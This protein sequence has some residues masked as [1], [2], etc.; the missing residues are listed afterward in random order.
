[1]FQDWDLETSRANPC[2]EYPFLQENHQRSGLC[3]EA[4]IVHKLNVWAKSTLEQPHIGFKDVIPKAMCIDNTRIED[5]QWYMTAQH[6]ATLDKDFSATKSADFFYVGGMIASSSLSIDEDST[7]VAN[8]DSSL[9]R[10]RS[11]SYCAQHWCFRHHNNW[12]FLLDSVKETHS[13]GRRA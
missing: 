3:V 2:V 1:M 6:Y 4:V 5:M 13:T 7:G 9:K 8:L 12:A 10:T 11:H